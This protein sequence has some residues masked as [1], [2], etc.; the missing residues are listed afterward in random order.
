MFEDIVPHWV[1]HF[2][3]KVVS[4]FERGTLDPCEFDIER[5]RATLEKR[6][7]GIGYSIILSIIVVVFCILITSQP[8][9]Y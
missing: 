8:S 3:R 5:P 7:E 1:R 6:S 2:T 9:P 4:L